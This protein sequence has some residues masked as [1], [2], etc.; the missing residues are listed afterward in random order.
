MRENDITKEALRRLPPDVYQERMYRLAKA[1][2]V[3][4][5]KAVLPKE[6]WIAPEQVRM[7]FSPRSIIIGLLIN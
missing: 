6:E 4:A 3:S 5:N 2:G 1:V 7:H